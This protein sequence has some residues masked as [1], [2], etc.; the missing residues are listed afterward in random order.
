MRLLLPA[1]SLVIVLA[2]CGGGTTAS[3][4]PE[5][6]AVDPRG[7][8]GLIA[9][10]PLTPLPTALRALGVPFR[11]LPS[12]D[13]DDSHLDG[14]SLVVIDE[15]AL[16]DPA[17]P[18]ALPRL[19]D[20]ARTA[21]LTVIM[22]SQSAEKGLAI[23]RR[24]SAPFEPRPITHGVDLVTPQRD[25]R[26]LRSPNVIQSID[27][28]GYSDRTNQFARGRGGR[29]ILAG[30][31][32]RPD[33]AAALLRVPYGKGSMWYVAFPIVARAAEGFAGE[34]RMLANLLSI[35]AGD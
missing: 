31:I 11:Q 13:L 3:S 30:N 1:I 12:A 25:H 18:D 33:S 2:A 34:Q 16:D 9:P 4:L 23:M 20:H 32:D 26:L 22:L 5:N 10:A 27:I 14:L 15:G 7:M 28:D 6:I 19:F 21:G 8:V 35:G 17:V 24:N 29:A